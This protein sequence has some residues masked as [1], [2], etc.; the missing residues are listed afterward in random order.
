MISR[1]PQRACTMQTQEAILFFILDLDCQL[2]VLND[3]IQR[4]NGLTGI[5]RRNIYYSICSWHYLNSV[6]GA[7]VCLS[8]VSFF[9]GWVSI[10]PGRALVSSVINHKV[11]AALRWLSIDLLRYFAEEA[12]LNGIAHVQILAASRAADCI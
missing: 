6:L 9:I 8:T 11:P 10:C 3:V 12:D 1:R 5:G 7:R 4:D 2:I